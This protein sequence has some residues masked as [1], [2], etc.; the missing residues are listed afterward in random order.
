MNIT[1]EYAIH[2]H[3]YEKISFAFRG[4]LVFQ[5]R[6]SLPVHRLAFL[7]D[8]SSADDKPQ[9][10]SSDQYLH[11]Q[12]MKYSNHP[13]SVTFCQCDRQWSGRFCSIPH[14]ST[15]ASDSLYIGIPDDDYMMFERKFVCLCSREFYG[16]RCEFVYHQLI[17]SFSNEIVPSQSI[18][19]HFIETMYNIVRQFDQRLLKQF[20]SAESL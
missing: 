17:L 7:V 19:V 4:G 14:H 10:C 16:D 6:F 18:F 1:K 20:L 11:G 3:V 15:C 2:M 9:N 12:C 8:I 5:V 13:E